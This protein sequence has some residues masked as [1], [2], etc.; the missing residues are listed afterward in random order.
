[1]YNTVPIMP[2]VEYMRTWTAR[3]LS[4]TAPAHKS[5]AVMEQ[6]A[7][8]TNFGALPGIEQ[9]FALGS[10]T[11]T[12]VPCCS[13]LYLQIMYEHH[14]KINTHTLYTDRYPRQACNFIH[15]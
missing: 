3:I 7:M 4:S 9:G 12:T 8:E 14:V 15:V 2:R 6:A 13:C 10:K 5:D 1:M 11:L